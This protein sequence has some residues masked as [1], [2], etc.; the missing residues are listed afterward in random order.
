MPVHC[1]FQSAFLCSITKPIYMHV[2]GSSQYSA[3][4]VGEQLNRYINLHVGQ[5]YLDAETVPICKLCCAYQK[6]GIF[7]T[8]PKSDVQ[9]G[10]MAYMKESS[11]SRTY[12]HLLPEISWGTVLKKLKT[13]TPIE[14]YRH[15]T[16]SLASD[17]NYPVLPHLNIIYNIDIL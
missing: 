12:I 6:T 8:L 14:M 5:C 17:P 9:K 10:V 15:M 4:N 1:A 3:K 11:K 2:S 16:I 13:S 7:V